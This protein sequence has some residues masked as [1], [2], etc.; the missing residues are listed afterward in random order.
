MKLAFAAS[1]P[2]T[3]GIEWE[4][5]L[6]DS[7]TL[8]LTPAASRVLEAV[9]DPKT[10]PIRREYLTSM[11]E[12]VTG[13][14]T[15]VADAV[16]ELGDLLGQLRGLLGDDVVPI[17]AG[18]HPTSLAR[19]QTH[20]DVERYQVVADRNGWWGR[21]MI[22]QGTHVHVGVGHVAKALPITTGLATLCPF[23]I[24]LSGS[25]PFWQGED[26]SFASNRT[27]LF[28]QLHT[29]GLPVAMESWD[30]F[31]AYASSLEE[32]GMITSMSEIRWDVRPSAF[33]TVENR[34][35]DSVP[36]LAELAAIAALTQCAAS[37]LA[38]QLDEGHP[39]LRLPAWFLQENKWRAARYGLDADIITT[40][41]A[42][43]VQ[44]LRKRLLMWLDRLEPYARRH[45]CE[46]ELAWCASLLDLGASCTRQRAALAAS[47]NFRDVTRLLIAETGA[48]AP[49]RTAG[50]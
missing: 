32:V 36:T 24:A 26:T 38:D 25:S 31:S 21:Q 18:T 39:L 28:Q 4:V 37:W 48:D 3:I 17:G 16:A 9:A 6:V 46:A 5:A 8:E 29:N 41:A 34:L 19:E 30:E 49:T 22:T 40:D 27:M 7:T 15:R 50:G 33:G 13:V 44:P 42:H 12:L 23:F 14:H 43:R 1:D 45:A 35:A 10:G 20:F 2:G 11:V 47:G